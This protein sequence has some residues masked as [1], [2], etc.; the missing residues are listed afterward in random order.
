MQDAADHIEQELGVKRRRRPCLFMV[1]RNLDKIDPDE[2][3]IEPSAFVTVPCH[4][5]PSCSRS[6]QSRSLQLDRSRAIA[7]Y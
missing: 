2:R 5:I 4:F 6:C 7:L 1:R 3:E